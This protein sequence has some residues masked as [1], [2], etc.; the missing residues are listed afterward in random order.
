[1]VEGEVAE[2]TLSQ[3]KWVRFTLK[4]LDGSALL[5][6]FLTIY[7]LNVDIKDG[8]RI[9]VHATPK[10]YA[11][12]GTL[13]LNINSIETVGE[14]GLKAALE[15]LQKQLREEGLFDETRKRPLPELPNRIGLITSRD[16]A[17]CSDFI[18]ILSNRWGDVDVELAHVHVQG[19]RAVPEICGA[20]THFNALPQSDR[21]D[22]L[23]LTRGGGSLEDL[24]AFNAEAVV[25]AVFA[26]RIPIVV[27]VGHERD[28]TLAEYAADVRAS[29]PSNA[30]E[31]LVPER[32]AMLQQ[33]CMHADRLRARVD[34]YLAQRGLLVERSVSRMQSVMA[35]VHLALSETI[36]TVE[37]AGEAMLAR[38][39]AHRRHIHTLVTLIRELDPARVLRRGYAMVKKSGRVVTSAKELDKGDRIS[40]HLA[41][42][43]VDAAVL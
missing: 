1:M 2:Y 30:A 9:I 24:M 31:R 14:G 37:H 39:E 40:V 22:V 16:A 25:R 29:T 36:Q 18:R 35:R 20:L 17:A 43:Q 42:G 33:V 5:K 28:E 12:Y 11:P 4:D 10:V 6:C 21:P 19:E 8:D 34:D 41:E 3:K 26:S 23:V 15:R 7:Q 32:A 38:I 27:A 13:T